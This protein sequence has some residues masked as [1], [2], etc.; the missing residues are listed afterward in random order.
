M[1]IRCSSIREI[2]LNIGSSTCVLFDLDDTLIQSQTQYGS[3]KWFS[4]ESKR[5]KD[6]GIDARAVYEILH[7]QSMA[8]LKLCPIALVE[9]CIPQ[10]VATAQQLAACVMGLTARHPEMKDITLEQLQQFDLD[11]SRHSFWP[12]PIFTTSGPSLFSE[13]IWFLSIL[14]QKG[15]SIRQWFDEVKPPIT[16]IVYVDDSL[17]H[18][19]N[20]EQM[21]HPDIAAIQK[22]A[23]PIILTD[24]EA[25]IVN[26]RTSCVT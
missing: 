7:P 1:I 15:D 12:I 24:E 13:G 10:V 22:L 21:M 2:L 6:Q 16:R 14:N 9:S 26:N 3:S 18:L 17:I 11:F 8:T 20:M 4:W 23:F 25:E 5:L 19:E